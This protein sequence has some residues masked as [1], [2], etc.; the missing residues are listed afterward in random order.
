MFNVHELGILLVHSHTL[1][2]ART[3]LFVLELVGLANVA[4]L[5]ERHLK[6]ESKRE[7]EKHTT[8]RRSSDKILTGRDRPRLRLTF[9]RYRFGFGFKIAC[10]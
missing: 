3:R 4:L 5:R 1:C 7:I 10:T 2:V 9:F 8:T 6:A